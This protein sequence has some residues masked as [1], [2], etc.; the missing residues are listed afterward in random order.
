MLQSLLPTFLPLIRKHLPKVEPA[1]INYL[2]KYPP[3]PGEKGVTVMLDIDG[4]KAFIA[5]VGIDAQNTITRV[6]SRERVGQ[7]IEKLIKSVNP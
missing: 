2:H 7:F 1:L 4:E 3:A 6:I 5:I